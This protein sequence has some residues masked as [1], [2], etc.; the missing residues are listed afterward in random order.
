MATTDLV[1]PKLGLTMT[2]GTVAR[3]DVAPGGR[4]AAGDTI[5]VVETDKIAY[6]VEAPGPGILQE[7][8]VAQG[9]AVPVGTP[10]GRWDI[11][12]VDIGNLDIG[13]MDI[14]DV[15]VALDAQAT[16]ALA[17]PAVAVAAGI[18]MPAVPRS[19]Q[20]RSNGR[21]I[22]ATPFARR[23]ARQAGIDWRALKGTGPRGR[24]KATDVETAIDAHRSPTP[25]AAPEA[26]GAAMY[27]AGVEIDVTALLALNE[28]INNDLPGFHAE[29]A[30]YVVLA[31]AKADETFD[32]PAVFGFARD[33]E[34]DFA[35]VRQLTAADCRTLSGVVAQSEAPPPS[36]AALSRQGTLWIEQAQDRIAFLAADPP[37]GWSASLNIGAVRE[38]FRPDA[39]GRPVRAAVIQIVLTGRAAALGPATAQRLLRRLQVLL[40]TPLLLLA[41]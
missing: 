10:I 24:I 13:D 2:E 38:V 33:G 4:F 15:K 39:D 37:Y 27:R 21:R 8:L 3:W 36:S 7:V 22:P 31:A 26:T 35:H 25:Q 17:A 19:S 9:N 1:M 6:D 16:Q 41:S 28:Q 12:D 18:E 29:L 14:R 30:H 40:E 20:Q 23:L 34:G 32:E 5:L 11:G